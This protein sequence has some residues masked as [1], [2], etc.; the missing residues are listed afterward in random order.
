MDLDAIGPA[1]SG[2]IGG[3]IAAMLVARWA[4]NLPASFN[5]KSRQ[6]LRK[7]HRSA[8]WTANVLFFAGLLFG[9]ALYPLGGFSDNDWRPLLW[10]WGLAS[11]LPLVALPTISLVA[12][13]DVKE[14][15]VAYALAQGSPLWATY[16]ILGAG[17]VGFCFAVGD[18]LT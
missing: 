5:F 7:Q 4:R 15:Y 8:I 11:L 1:V 18:V 9:L 16:G 3:S 13:R 6:T 2:V 17:V 14:A 10:G 12:G